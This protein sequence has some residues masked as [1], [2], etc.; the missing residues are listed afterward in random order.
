MKADWWDAPI[1]LWDLAEAIRMPLV[2]HLYV[3]CMYSYVIHM[4]LA[5]IGMPSV[6]HSYV[7]YVTRMSLVCTCMS[8]VC[9]SY[10]LV[11]HSYFIRMSLVCSRMSFACHSSVVLPW[12]RFVI[13]PIHYSFFTYLP[14][15]WAKS[16]E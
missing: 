3:T 11:F 2:C 15:T 8:P 4:S 14:T 10:A 7:L 16:Y 9:H 1:A 5:C 12:P 13:A 6:C